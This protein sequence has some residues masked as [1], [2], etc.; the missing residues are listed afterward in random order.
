M[1]A[2]SI[3]S[4]T[5]CGRYVGVLLAVIAAFTGFAAGAAEA[6][7]RWEFGLGLGVLEFADYRGS[8]TSHVYPLPLPYFIYR[9]R[10]LRAGRNGVRSRLLSNDRFDVDLSVSA[11]TPVRSRSNRARAG[12]PDLKP[13]VE[14]GPA[15]QWHWWQSS[16]HRE[17]IELRAP[18]RGALTL[19]TTPQFIGMSFAP[20]VNFDVS[21]VARHSGWQLGAQMGP[22]FADHRYHDYIYGVNA[23]FATAARPVYRSRGGYAGTQFVLALSKRFTRHWAGAFVRFDAL[24]GAVFDSS[25]LFRKHSYWTFGM[26]LTWQLAKSAQQVEVRDDAL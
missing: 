25:P 10:I 20:T 23:E 15:L 6:P 18:L 2:Q 7:A 5:G 17:R 26:G 13:T 3:L 4:R 16:D 11:T 22:L 24:N 14:V 8:D 9:G 19:E 1:T 21:D 12:M